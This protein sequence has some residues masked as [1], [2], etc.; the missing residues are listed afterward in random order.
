M[1]ECRRELAEEQGVPAYVIFHDSTLREIAAAKPASAAAL[2]GVKGIGASKLERYGEAVLACV[3]AETGGEAIAPV[4]DPEE[5]GEP[6][7]P[8]GDGTLRL[9]R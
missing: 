7:G 1:R 3:R 2:G 8:A 6:D 5:S 9:L 4:L